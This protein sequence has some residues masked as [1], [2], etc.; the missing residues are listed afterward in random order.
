MT[1]GGNSEGRMT[2]WKRFFCFAAATVG[3]LNAGIGAEASPVSAEDSNY[4]SATT[5]PEAWQTFARLL[6]GRIEQQLAGDDERARRFQDYLAGGGNAADAPSP[7]FVLRAWVLT[8][9][10]VDRVEFDG[11]D[12]A[13][14]IINLRA[15][16]VG[17]NVGAPPP[18]MLQPLHLRLSLR[19]KDQ[20]RQDQ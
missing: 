15:L 6:Q 8:D 1:G 7:T 14:A 9:G 16:L 3:F 18:E 11:I 4:R 13:D 20:P 12:D 19:A 17:D 5:A 10:R 2:W